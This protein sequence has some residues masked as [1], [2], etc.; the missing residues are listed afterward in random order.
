[1]LTRTDLVVYGLT[2]ITPTAAYPMFG[3]VQQVSLGHAALSY[4]IAMV[5][6]LFTAASYGRMAAAFP[7]AGS[8]YT[9]AQRAL[10]GHVGFLA[11]WSMILDYVLVPLLSAVY[12]S[13]TAARLAPEV[14][15]SVWAFLFALTITV[16]N[17]RGIQV[18][19]RASEVMTIIMTAST[20]LFVAC[21]IHFTVKAAGLS[22]LFVA[23]R[24][25]DTRTLQLSPLMLGAGVATLSYL[26]FDAISTLAEESR[27]P[28]KDIGF[29]TIL[30]CLLQTVFCF[31]IVYL[32]AVVWPA[33][34]PF[35]NVETAILDVTQII[36]GKL[37]F[38]FTTFVL[39]IAGV[40]SS[41]TSQAGASRMLYGMGRDGMLPN[42]IFGYL[43]P[44]YATPTRSIYLM[45]AISFIGAL[46]VSFQMVVELVNFGA[47]VGFI[48][49]N[50]SVIAHYYGKLRQRSGSAL[51]SNLIAPA[52]G[53][54]I[55]LYVW[56]SLSSKAMLVGFCWLAIGT[57]YCAILTKGFRQP[58][59]ELKTS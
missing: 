40:A 46:L 47:F 34:K 29:A 13:I 24:L 44:R 30:V 57:I 21:A 3:I 18:T 48:L 42:Y 2:I 43:H 51:W 19:T 38:G 50:L 12:V 27:H 22:G 39:L 49:V 56:T 14:P 9:Y 35:A 23:E 16:V 7:V 6:M 8:T 36:G 33:G 1:M 55:C 4:L 54:V 26:G 10:N 5:A 45:G 58:A 25:V 28:E 59:V 52:L 41:L 20:I 32:A 53:A 15:Y 31:A 11:G 17:V 37:L